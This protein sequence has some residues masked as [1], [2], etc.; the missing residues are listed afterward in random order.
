MRYGFLKLRVGEDDF[1]RVDVSGVDATFEEGGC[2]DAAGE[3]LAIADDEVG[4]ARG[5]FENRGQARAEL[6]RGNRI[7]DQSSCTSAADSQ[8]FLIEC[9]SGV[10]MAGSAGGN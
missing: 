9:R 3:A 7:S 1:A 8:G 5:E 10:A 2:N 4:D 6:R